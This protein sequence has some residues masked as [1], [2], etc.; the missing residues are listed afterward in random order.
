M[1]LDCPW[2]LN[3]YFQKNV[4]QWKITQFIDTHNHSEE[5]KP[6]QKLSEEEKKEIAYFKSRRI[7]PA[8]ITKMLNKE[9]ITLSKVC[10]VLQTETKVF[11]FVF[12]F[13]LF[14]FCYNVSLI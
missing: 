13:F 4:Q 5:L 7:P 2:G 8:Q 10:N 3:I 6:P 11:L 12:F 9:H 1:K 14:F